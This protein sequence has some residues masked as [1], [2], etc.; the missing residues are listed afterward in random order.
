MSHPQASSGGTAVSASQLQP[1]HSQEFAFATP[2]QAPSAQFITSPDHTASQPIPAAEAQSQQPQHTSQQQ[3]V[4][5]M[6]QQP[7]AREQQQQQ[8]HQQQPVSGMH[9]SPRADTAANPVLAST[10]MQGMQG[11]SCD[12]NR[13]QAGQSIPAWQEQQAVVDPVRLLQPSEPWDM[14]VAVSFD[15]GQGM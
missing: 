9:Q 14:L 15:Q 4:A 1:S 12:G 10:H 7:D 8:Q 6:Q 2:N 13:M 3:S 5:G 11:E